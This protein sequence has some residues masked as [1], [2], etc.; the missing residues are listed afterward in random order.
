MA[1]SDPTWLAR[2]SAATDYGQLDE[3]FSQMAAEARRPGA[4]AESLAAAIDAAI[5][6]IEEERARD[7]AQLAEFQQQ[8]DAFRETQ[9]GMVG[10]F[11]RHLPFT[12]TR[13]QEL[14]M[15]GQVSDQQSEILA[16][17]FVIARAEM[18]KQQLLPPDTR[19]LGYR[20]AEWHQQLRK[21]G[22]SQSLPAYAA[23][24]ERLGHELRRSESF[25]TQLKTD[26][27]AFADAR[28]ADRDDVARRDR[29]LDTAR[30]DL[31]EIETE[32]DEERKL[33]SSG[34]ERL[35]ELVR[36]D[37][38]SRDGEYRGLLQRLGVSRNAA[39]LLDRAR[40][41]ADQWQSTNQRLTDLR[42]QLS[43]LPQQLSE[44]Q[45][46]M[47]HLRDELQQ[48]EVHRTRAEA[49]L[50]RQSEI[51]DAA[52]MQL[53][54]AQSGLAAGRQVYDAYLKQQGSAEVANPAEL[55]VDSPVAVE[56]RR[57]Q[58]ALQVAQQHVNG[59]QRSYDAARAQSEHEL[60]RARSVQ[61][62][63]DDVQRQ[64]QQLSESESQLQRDDHQ[65][66][67]QRP[68]TWRELRG[69]IDGYLHQVQLT[70]RRPQLSQPAD[71]LD[72]EVAAK[73]LRQLDAEAQ[74]LQHAI[75]TDQSTCDD[76]WQAHCHQLLT[77]DL[78][79]ELT[80]R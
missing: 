73:W 29:N 28:F 72:P 54:R 38:A 27:D 19:A 61:Q 21:H 58:E 25:V 79:R 17:N 78:A 34:I 33:R 67:S 11:K 80:S 50:R 56:Y 31:H 16:D 74:Q 51:Y 76:R 69:A 66:T 1:N 14:N 75:A 15:R 36:D 18:L 13:R 71:V 49:E 48:A 57:L 32:L 63:L 43:R 3:L 30:K 70:G 46:N 62:K 77:P 44:L 55:E 42:H 5:R 7:T 41:T 6:R 47:E 39:S 60:A 8:Y 9:Q 45:K 68:T 37:L 59:L 20:P 52:R 23:A 40:T 64:Q 53:E 35:K 24:I 12:E 4:D 65:L 2:L 22:E 26:I 10:W